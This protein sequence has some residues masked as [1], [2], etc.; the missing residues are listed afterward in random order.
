MKVIRFHAY[1]T[2]QSL[3]A[4]QTDRPQPG[5]GEVLVKV[6]GTSFNPADATIRAGYLQE[7]F[8]VEMP[9][10]PG[11][12]VAGTV[13]E[14]GAGVTG[15]EVGDQ[16]MGFLPMTADGAAAEFVLAPAEVLG[17]APTAIPLA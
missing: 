11:V 3:R 15:F 9:H 2:A 17:P 10:T 4:E 12:D 13:A 5:T 14:I 1:G 8:P 7:V 16:V 6:A